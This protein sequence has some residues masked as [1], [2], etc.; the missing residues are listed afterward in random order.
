MASALPLPEPVFHPTY[1]RVLC[2][3]LRRRGIETQ[4]LLAGTGLAWADLLEGRRDVSFAQMR[5]LILT[6]IQLSGAPGL[7]MQLGL[8]MPVSAH[9]QVGNAVVASRNLAQALEG[10]ARYGRL[11]SGAVD[12]CLVRAEGNFRLQVHERFALGDVRIPILEAVLMG[13]M[14]LIEAVLGFAPEDAEFHLPYAA[15]PWQSAYTARFRGRI[16]FNADGME[17]RL[18]DELLA[19]PCVT[20][21]AAAYLSAQRDCED[22]LARLAPDQ[23]VVRQVRLRLRMC[24]ESYPGCEAMAAQLHMSAR[25]LIRKL[26]QH[27]SS[28]QALL[29]EVRKEQALWYLAHTTY[30]VESI[31]ER[32]GYLDTSN[33]SRTFRRW[34]GVPP[35]TFRKPA[36]SPRQPD[37]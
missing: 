16:R 30:S 24:G 9:G 18:P 35:N 19:L 32:L 15:P 4:R 27:G 29:D 10:I 7:G 28:Y 3:L 22:A 2:A 36:G 31:A 6:A 20:S 5:R 37:E 26:K 25:T 14:Q 33:F 11:R 21:D 1:A 8:V 34:F 12:F 17:I 13:V 23:D